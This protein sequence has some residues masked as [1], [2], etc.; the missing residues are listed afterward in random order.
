LTSSWQHCKRRHKHKRETA[1]TAPLLPECVLALLEA[2]VAKVNRLFLEKVCERY[3]LDMREVES[4]LHTTM[5]PSLLPV[6]EHIKVTKVY[7]PRQR[8]DE[9]DRCRARTFKKKELH[10]QQCTRRFVSG[11]R[12]CKTHQKMHDENILKYGT[13]DDA[14][15]EQISEKKLKKVVKKKLY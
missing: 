15:D 3:K 1:M 6:D 8:L 10:V 2:E 9:D 5:S 4:I 14:P 13:I 7:K 11:C 12:F